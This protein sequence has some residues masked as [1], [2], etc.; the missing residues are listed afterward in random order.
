[1][2]FNYSEVKESMWTQFEMDFNKFLIKILSIPANSKVWSIYP[3]SIWEESCFIYLIVLID[4]GILK[5]VFKKQFTAFHLPIG[6]RQSFR[7]HC[8]Q[9]STVEVV[10]V[11]CFSHSVRQ[12]SF[13]IICKVPKHYAN[14]NFPDD[15]SR[16]YKKLD[17][18]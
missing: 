14:Y 9:M 6:W 17:I 11:I 8:K 3:A 12:S 10:S 4:H 2:L 18:I 16:V 13:R 7:D 15:S 1:M 5:Y